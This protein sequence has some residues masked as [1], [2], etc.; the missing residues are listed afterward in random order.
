[1]LLLL[2][3][4]LAIDARGG[5][6]VVHSVGWFL[7]ALV[8]VAIAK[9]AAVDGGHSARPQNIVVKVIT[10]SSA[11]PAAVLLSASWLAVDPSTL[12]AASGL[13]I[14]ASLLLMIVTSGEPG[15]R[16]AARK[17]T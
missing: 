15:L 6:A 1:V 3:Q 2:L 7:A 12:F 16:M 8:P 5:P 13:S 10:S 9:S 17:Q 4:L 14:C 11:G